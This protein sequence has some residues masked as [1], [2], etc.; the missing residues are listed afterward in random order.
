MRFSIIIPAYNTEKWIRKCLESV[1]SQT[2]KDYE[3]I[4]I[5]DSCTDKT[6]QIAKEY[7]DKV[8]V[9][10]FHT[11]GLTRNRG[12]DLAKGEYVLFIDSD[13]WLLHEFVLEMLNKKIIQEKSPDII[14]FSFIIKGLMYAYPK[15]NENDYWTGAPTKCYRRKF[16]DGVRFTDKK[17]DSDVD[18]T[19]KLFK[20]RPVI[21]EWDMPLYYY[22]YL[23][24]GSYESI[25]HGK[26][27]NE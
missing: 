18:F 11:D 23:R 21:L 26:V 3:L 7:T 10:N 25:R 16:L 5:C 8:E 17:L 22:N 9:V 19:E 24:E 2:F 15:T 1:K 13:D 6:E 12:L 4:V 20:K 14:A 27:Q